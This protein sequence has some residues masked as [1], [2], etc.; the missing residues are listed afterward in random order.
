M[1][2][3]IATFLQPLNEHVEAFLCEPLALLHGLLILIA[4]EAR[5]MGYLLSS[6]ARR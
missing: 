3:Y 1:Y 5:G 6:P 2:S 4:E